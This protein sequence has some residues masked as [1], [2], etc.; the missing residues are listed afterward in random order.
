[1]LVAMV[2]TI[3]FV[4]AFGPQLQVSPAESDPS[5]PIEEV[6][7]APALAAEPEAESEANPVAIDAQSSVTEAAVLET[8]TVSDPGQSEEGSSASQ[9]IV[10][11]PMDS[12]ET[13]IIE[14]APEAVEADP[15]VPAAPPARRGDIPETEWPTI[16]SDASAA[17]ANAR[18]AKGNFVQTNGDGSVVTG[19]FALNRPGR[20]RFDYDDP[21]PVLIV[22]DGTT[23]AMEDSELETVDRVPIG[24]TPLGLILSTDLDV[25]TDIQVLSVLEDEERIGIRVQ[26]ATGELEGTLTMVFDKSTYDLLGWLAVDGNLQTTVVDLVDVETNVRIDPRLFR[27]NEDDDEDDER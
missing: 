7:E 25:D 16:L 18:T 22:S 10:L 9:P 8:Q 5:T 3:A 6:V 27:L 12:V 11:E 2:S 15:V 24:A 20:M 4:L 14:A 1:M 23:V 26:D 19:T 17:L 21:T 13:E